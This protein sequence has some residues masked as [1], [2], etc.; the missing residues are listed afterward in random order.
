MQYYSLII[1]FI[2]L[3]VRFQFLLFIVHLP[4]AALFAVYNIWIE[5]EV[6]KTFWLQYSII[7]CDTYFLIFWHFLLR[8][9]FVWS[10]KRVI[11]IRKGPC[12]CLCGFLDKADW[13]LSKLRFCTFFCAN[14]PKKC[15]PTLHSP[16]HSKLN[17]IH[18]LTISHKSYVHSWA[19]TNVSLDVYERMETFSVLGT[20]K[21]IVFYERTCDSPSSRRRVKTVVDLFQAFMD[22]S[23]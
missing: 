2:Y 14:Y 15:F 19:F 20:A 18:S 6:G 11:K 23:L 16:K 10:I 7:V 4:S 21:Y 12:W 8:S 3:L 13:W 1:L 9:H 5:N 22:R 17:K